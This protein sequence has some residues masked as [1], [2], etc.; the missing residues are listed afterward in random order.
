MTMST[1]NYHNRYFRSIA[2]TPNGEVSGDT[3]FHY[4]QEGNIV[5]AVYRGGNI[6]Y[7]TL[8]AKV[9]ADGCLDMRYQHLNQKGDFM[10]GKCRSTPTRLPDGRIRL[11][12]EW[13]W[14]SG[15]LSSGTS[16]II[17]TNPPTTP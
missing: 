11:D 8:I 7:G 12:E 14:T 17:E 6:V 5:S 13:Q 16:A 2:N 1:F 4:Q 3:V 15:D 10:T 9:D